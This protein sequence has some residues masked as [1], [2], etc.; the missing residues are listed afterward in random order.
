[1]YRM[2]SRQPL[3]DCVVALLLWTITFIALAVGNTV[4]KFALVI[5]NDSYTKGKGRLKNTVSDANLMA[6]SLTTLGFT[7]TKRPNL[8]RSQM[9]AEIT[10]FSERLP[11]GSTALVYYAGHGIQVDGSNYLLPVDMKPFENEASVPNNAYPLKTLLDRLSA[12]KAAVNIVVLDACRVNPFQPTYVRYRSFANLG[13]AS[14]Q[15]PRGTLVAFSTAPG[16]QAAD[17]K[18]ANSIYTATLAKVM[19]E[20]KLEIREIF[21]KT[22]SVVRKKTLDDQIPWLETSITENYYFLPPEGITVVAGKPLQMASAGRSDT[23]VKRGGNSMQAVAWFNNL[24]TNEWDQL[25]AEIHQRAIRMTADEIPEMEHRANSGSVVIQTVLGLVYRDGVDKMVDTSS[26]KIF[27]SNASNLKAL[28]W[29]TKAAEAGFPVAQVELGEMYATGHGVDRD[30]VVARRWLEAAAR[31]DYPKGKKALVE[32][33]HPS[34][35]V[36]PTVSPVAVNEENPRI[37]LQ[38]MGVSW[39]DEAVAQA[40]GKNDAGTVALFAKGKYKFFSGRDPII[41]SLSS[42]NSPE[43]AQV[44]DALAAAGVDLTTRFTMTGRWNEEH[45]TDILTNAMFWY[46]VNLVTALI[47]HGVLPKRDD[48]YPTS[49]SYTSA[50]VDGQSGYSA[51]SFVT[52]LFAGKV[53]DIKKGGCNPVSSYST[54]QKALY[55]LLIDKKW[56]TKAKIIE[57]L[58]ANGLWEHPNCKTAQAVVSSL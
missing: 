50:A 2:T 46:D 51:F 42:N 8:N 24:T 36:V 38:K 27:R 23:G 14:V 53:S 3:R 31:A 35:P 9:L 34:P 40:F 55:K 15:A 11:E 44:I 4:D 25:D 52:V 19:L 29:L 49:F 22:A 6:Q 18:E 21:Q 45:S 57:E 5:G 32:F 1:M 12:S 47:N 30:L 58:K 10:N 16:Q 28:P 7:V 26:D 17:G 54:Q 37:A 41:R 48:V 56:I 33:D 39:T 20:P 43:V 13:L